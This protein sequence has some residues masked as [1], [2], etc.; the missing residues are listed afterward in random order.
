MLS[1]NDVTIL[2]EF[3]D[4]GFI[5][6]DNPP[7]N[8]IGF[9]VREGLLKGVETFNKR[10]TIKA[11]IIIC[12]NRTFFAGVDIKEFNQPVKEPGLRKVIESLKDNCF[13]N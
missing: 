6:V 12:E 7:V 9:K 10:D 3:G 2:E 5:I 11:I 1:T 8:A 4:I 13:K